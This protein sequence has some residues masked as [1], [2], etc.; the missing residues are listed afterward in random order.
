[1]LVLKRKVGESV[2][3]ESRSG[4]MVEVIFLGFDRGQAKIGFVA[5]KYVHILRTELLEEKDDDDH[6]N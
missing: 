6:R 1:M 2:Q 5:P 4:D 3:L